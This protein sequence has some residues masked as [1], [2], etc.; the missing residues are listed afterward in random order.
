MISKRMATSL[1]SACRRGEADAKIN[2]N[3]ISDVMRM[4]ARKIA[5]SGLDNREGKK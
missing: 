2:G 3:L 4:N 5:K 1:R